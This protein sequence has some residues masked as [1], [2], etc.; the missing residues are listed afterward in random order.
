[1]E[2]LRNKDLFEQ[3]IDIGEWQRENARRNDLN[4]KCFFSETDMVAHSLHCDLLMNLYRTEI[5]LGKEMNV[6]KK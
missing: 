6:V 4:E 5:K 1:M 3:N 2:E